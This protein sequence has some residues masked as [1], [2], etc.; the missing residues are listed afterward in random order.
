MYTKYNTK[1]HIEIP[2]LK[3]NMTKARIADYSIRL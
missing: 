2:G 3:F 1:R